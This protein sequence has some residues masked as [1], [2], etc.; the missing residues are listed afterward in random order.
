MKLA[1]DRFPKTVAI[2][3]SRSFAKNDPTVDRKMRGIVTKFVN[4][5]YFMT[6]V[7]SGEAI[8]V[9]RYAKD[10][11]VRRKGMIYTPFAPN[12]NTPSPQRY[13]TRNSELVKYIS[14]SNGI[15][16]AFID[17]SDCDG[18]MDT[19]DKAQRSGVE[20]ITYSFK[21]NGDFFAVDGA[22]DKYVEVW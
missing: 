4:S 5:L 9:D 16:V 11:A 13:F 14:G 19:L 10:A 17:I 15:I 22:L 21:P 20:H 7:V 3:G 1:F 6:E 18:T 8:G 2:V 12:M